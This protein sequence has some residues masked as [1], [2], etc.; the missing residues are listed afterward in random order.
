VAGRQPKT[1]GVTRTACALVLALA[2]LAGVRSAHADLPTLYVGYNS[3]DCTFKLTNDNGTTFTTIAPGTYQL[4]ITTPD[5]FGLFGNSGAGDLQACRG[6]VQFRLTGPGVSLFTTLDYGDAA[7]ELYSET[8]KAGGTYTLQDDGNIA[9]TRRTF[10]VAASGPAVTT[11][12]SPSTTSSGGAAVAFR[13]V[14]DV[15]VSARGT[16]VVTRKGEKIGGLKA[17]RYTFSV[18][19]GSKKLGF[20]IQGP[21]AKPQAVTNGVYIGFRDLGVVLTPGR[22]TFFVPGGPSTSFGVVR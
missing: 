20:S 3:A 13:G 2:L 16:L 8:F 11:S 21:A 6:Y 7:S 12:S 1:A 19:D 5:P 15:S 17:G 10:T 14:L 22:W 9:N 4:S 18:H